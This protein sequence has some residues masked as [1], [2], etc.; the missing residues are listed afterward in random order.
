MRTVTPTDRTLH[1]GPIVD[2]DGL[3]PPLRH[4][5]RAHGG[6]LLPFSARNTAECEVHHS[7]T[8]TRVSVMLSWPPASIAAFHSSKA[9]LLSSDSWSRSFRVSLGTRSES[10]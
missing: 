3:P 6:M 10:T 2:E 4:R 5:L 8:R 7:A 1:S 9:A